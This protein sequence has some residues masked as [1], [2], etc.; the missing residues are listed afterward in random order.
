MS[1]EVVIENGTQR[2]QRLDS[3]PIITG[4]EI[5]HH[6]DKEDR[7]RKRLEV[8]E[9]NI[10]RMETFK[11]LKDE[12]EEVVFETK[13]ISGLTENIGDKYV[14]S[15][16]EC[17]NPILRGSPDII[18]QQ[19]LTCSETWT[20][21]KDVYIGAI[22]YVEHG[23][24][25]ARDEKELKGKGIEELREILIREIENRMPKHCKICNDWY[26][27]KLQDRPEI[28]CMWCKVGIH[29][30]IEINEEIGQI[31]FKWLCDTCDPVFLKHFMPK[32]DQ[33]A[34]FDGFCRDMRGKNGEHNK[35]KKQE[36]TIAGNNKKANKEQKRNT[37]K[38]EKG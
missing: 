10:R 5:E 17:F 33:A 1:N 30:C 29:D 8:N 28:H 37:S 31:G 13:V 27:V 20:N 2:R 6:E 18:S 23:R 4:R 12:D 21:K 36:T 16:I 24:Q 26:V 38:E 7:K 34:S 14:T 15:L 9:N 35:G 19:M 11:E 32:L 25:D 22:N 3:L